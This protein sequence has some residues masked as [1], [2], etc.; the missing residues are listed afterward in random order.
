MCT[1]YNR[2]SEHEERCTIEDMQVSPT[3]FYLY[4]VL[5]IAA[6]FTIVGVAG[7]FFLN[8][9]VDNSA[10]DTKRMAEI[11]QLQTRA[12][13]YFARV[14]YYDGVCKEIGA[15]GVYP[16]YESETAY[17]TGQWLTNYTFYCADST[18]YRGVA[19]A[20]TEGETQCTQ[21]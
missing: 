20:L 9:N 1:V 4:N 16:C 15:R 6:I 10:V 17:A 14:R 7:Y 2:G 12:G 3:T 19:R 8:T 5:A 21:P 13:T 11:A 18:G